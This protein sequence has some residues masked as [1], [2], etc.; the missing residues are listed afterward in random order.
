MNRKHSNCFYIKEKDRCIFARRDF[1]SYS[2]SA[3][4]WR[5]AT[6]MASSPVSAIDPLS[7][8]YDS[9]KQSFI[10]ALACPDVN[11]LDCSQFERATY[12]ADVVELRVDHLSPD[13]ITS[14]TST[15]PVDYAILQIKALRKMTDL[16]ILFTIRTAS[17]GGK[18]PD[19]AID[20]ARQLMLVAIETSCE[21][22]DIEV[23]WPESLISDIIRHNRGTKVIA[24]F[25]D[26]TGNVPWTLSSLNVP[27]HKAMEFGGEKHQSYCSGQAFDM[28]LLP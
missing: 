21:Y 24:S 22:L 16:P 23:T 10:V 25:H 5:F 26:W 11:Q 12:G 13:S 4:L 14:T 19:H 6:E 28:Q 2:H 9:G 17:Q 27:Y 1:T 8:R 18:F 3:Q 20:E 7:K 15:P